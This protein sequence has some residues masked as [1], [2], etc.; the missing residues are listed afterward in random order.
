MKPMTRAAMIQIIGLPPRRQAPAGRAAIRIRP[1]AMEPP[2]TVSAVVFGEWWAE[3]RL[4]GSLGWPI[5]GR[6][7]AESP[8]FWAVDPVCDLGGGN[9]IGFHAA[10]MAAISRPRQ[11]RS[12]ARSAP[13]SSQS[14]S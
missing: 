6:I 5:G 2:A 8:A 9:D 13:A 10:I 12:A 14:R 11:P 3:F 7:G 4:A 1:R